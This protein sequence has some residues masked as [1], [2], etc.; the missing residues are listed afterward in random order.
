MTSFWQIETNRRNARLSTG[1]VRAKE[2]QNAV[3]RGLT[4]ETAIDALEDAE[5]HA[6]STQWYRKCDHDLRR[7]LPRT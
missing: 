3:R 1:P 4:A 7:A 5:D 6:A 2:S